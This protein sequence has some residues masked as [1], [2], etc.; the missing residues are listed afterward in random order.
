MTS[1]VSDNYLYEPTPRVLDGY[2]FRTLL[3]SESS[4]YQLG[5]YVRIAI[6]PV[7]N[8]F[9]NTAN[10]WVNITIGDVVLNGTALVQDT[11]TKAGVRH[12]IAGVHSLIDTC[13]I[14]SPNGQFLEHT[15]NYQA[16]QVMN[17]INNTDL[18][19]ALP[20]SI[21]N[22]TPDVDNTFE[23]FTTVNGNSIE[24]DINL[25]GTVATGVETEHFSPTL[26]CMLNGTKALPISW[27]ASDTHLELLLTKDILSVFHNAS[28]NPTGPVV[29]LLGSGSCTI[30]VE[31]DAMIDV[32]TDNSMTMIKK[33]AGYGSGRPVS[34]SGTQQRSSI[35]S[36]STA[37]L[38]TTGENIKST[39]IGG[40][41]P[42]KLLSIQQSAFVNHPSGHYDRWQCVNPYSNGSFQMRIGTQLYP[43]R[44]ME[45]AAEMVQHV[46]K[47]YNQKSLTVTNNRLKEGY[48][49]PRFNEQ[50]TGTIDTFRGTCGYD[51]TTFDGNSDGLD[52]T[53]IIIETLGGL[54][55]PATSPAEMAQF[56]YQIVTMKRFQVLYSCDDAGN[57]SVSY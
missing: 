25:T 40:V 18:A 27:F 52:T 10:S 49:G 43:P 26:S 46:Q 28:Y 50:G 45:S 42:R 21:T 31:I 13:S 14:V 44:P 30:T 20:N 8:G 24:L 57:V 48:Y 47:C 33:K 15:P 29:G 38:N 17:W 12:S 1:L 16:Q 11:P 5:D 22:N 51:F 41:R 53:N 6:P 37:E 23:D 3:S 55:S 34:W 35:H 7:S 56:P 32:V 9:L 4:S 19:A 54:K 36:I 39:I 2:S